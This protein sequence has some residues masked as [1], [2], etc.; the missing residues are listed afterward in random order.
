M[1]A[2]EDFGFKDIS[3]EQLQ[4]SVENE[5]QKENNKMTDEEVIDLVSA[6]CRYG[7]SEA[8]IA[9]S[10]FVSNWDKTN[11]NV[12]PIAALQNRLMGLLNENKCRP[13]IWDKIQEQLKPTHHD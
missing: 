5:A 11:A 6:F 4:K 7:F 8:V 9:M 10:D 12:I 3:P 13:I 1:S 2:R